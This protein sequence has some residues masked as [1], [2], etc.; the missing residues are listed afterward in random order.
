LPDIWFFVVI[1]Q[2]SCGGD[3]DISDLNPINRNVK[4]SYCVSKLRKFLVL[5]NVIITVKPEILLCG[6]EIY[7]S[8]LQ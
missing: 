5:Q 4:T 1:Y 7:F 6:K 8:L 2:A 3:K